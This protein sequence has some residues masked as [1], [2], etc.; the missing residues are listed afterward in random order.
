MI[1][2]H[3]HFAVATDEEATLARVDTVAGEG[4]D[5]EFLGSMNGLRTILGHRMGIERT[6]YI[7]KP[8]HSTGSVFWPSSKIST[9]GVIQNQPI[10]SSPES[11]DFDLES[12]H[13]AGVERL[14]RILA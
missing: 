5:L 1:T 3:T 10:P 6:I 13:K 11:T 9:E 2:S 8:G 7:P 12:G 14:E 4:V